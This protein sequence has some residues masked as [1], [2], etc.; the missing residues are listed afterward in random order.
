MFFR[1]VFESL[2]RRAKSRV[3]ALASVALG[4][5]AASGLVMILLGVGDRI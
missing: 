2:R 5:G 4:A 1:L 3:A